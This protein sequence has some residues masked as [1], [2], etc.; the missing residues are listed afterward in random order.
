MSDNSASIESLKDKKLTPYE[1]WDEEI[2]QA[3]LELKDFHNRGRKVNRRFLDERDMLDSSNKWFNIYYANT[4]IMESALYA[5]LPKPSV[6]RRFKDYDDDVARVA[7]TIIQRSITQDL[8]DPRDAFDSTMRSCVQDRLIPGLAAAW[9]RLETDTEDVPY[10]EAMGDT[11]HPGDATDKPPEPLKKIIDQRVCIDYVYWQDFIWS[12]CRTWEE[13]RWVGRKAYMSRDALVKRF[14]K[15][16]GGAVSL[17][18]NPTL[19]PNHGSTPGTT[20]KHMAIK[21]ACIYEI[22]DREK[23]EVI[24]FSKGYKEI[25]DTKPDPLKLVGFEPCPRPMFANI[26]TSNT[27]PRPDYYMI[28]DQY[29]ELDTINNRVSMLLQ[30]CKVVGVYD[31]SAS[32]VSRMLTEGFDNQLI[33]VDN[34]AMFAEKGGLKGQVDWLPLDVVVDALTQLITNRDLIKAQIY[35]LT[36]ISDIVRGASKASE[37]LG[38]QEIKSKFASI[39]IKK[40]QDEVAR[41]A[42]DLLRLKAEIQVKHFDDEF[43]LKNSNIVATGAENVKLIEPALALLHADEGFEWRIQVTADSIAQA[44]YAM[45]KADRIEFLTAVGGYLEKAMPMMTTIP[46]SATFLIGMLKWAVAGFRNSAEIEGMLDKE[47]DALGKQ[48]PPPPKPDPDEK[49]MELEEKKIQGKMQADEQKA[50]LDMQKGQQEL[51]LKERLGEME[52]QMKQ[53]ELKFK[54]QEMQ[55]KAQEN[56][57]NLQFKQA[58]ASQDQQTHAAETQMELDARSQEHAMDIEQQRE[59]HAMESEQAHEDHELSMEQTKEQGKV[60][61]EVMKQQAAAKPKPK[62]AGGKK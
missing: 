56:Q 1:R 25:L 61:T 50:N 17:D 20:P 57:M 29:Q 14:G 52:L 32:G 38:A 60:K 2:K 24:W 54:E 4:N 22:W 51:Q 18:F 10:Q 45:E 35:E 26:T 40:R 3:E 43:L 49:K 6:S 47:L 16:I 42:G 44:D 9:L 12:P 34:W 30:A 23:K 55:L 59:S 53:M 58:E 7:G 27:V 8:D 36:G 11:F 15:K 48:P 62:P 33:P 13:R 39:A 41:F 19:P 28:Q 31:Q 46:A 21:Q 5:Q 37:T